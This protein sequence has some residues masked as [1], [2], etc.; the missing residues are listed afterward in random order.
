MN[1]KDIVLS[2]LAFNGFDGLVNNHL[3]CACDSKD[4]MPCTEP[5]PDCERGYKVSCPG[6]QD[7]DVGGDCEFHIATKK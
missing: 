1:I 6:P 3:G 4:L 2:H 5:S 7:C